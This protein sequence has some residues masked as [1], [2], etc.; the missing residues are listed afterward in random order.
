MAR[1]RY[2]VIEDD[3][4]G[5][6]KWYSI[7]KNFGFILPQDDKDEDVFLHSSYVRG[8]WCPMEGDSVTFKLAVDNITSRVYAVDVHYAGAAK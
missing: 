7:E 4:K 6:I 3:C 5:T 1:L 8:T 2:R